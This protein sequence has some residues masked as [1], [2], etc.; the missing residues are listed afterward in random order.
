[1]HHFQHFTDGYKRALGS[2]SVVLHCVNHQ[3]LLSLLCIPP[4]IHMFYD[5]IFP[6]TVHNSYRFGTASQKRGAIPV[7]RLYTSTTCWDLVVQGVQGD[8]T[9]IDNW[10]S[11]KMGYFSCIFMK[12]NTAAKQNKALCWNIQVSLNNYI[13]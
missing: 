4:L 7:G 5:P 8:G 3:L 9:H 12:I 2:H 13:T 6:L 1:M 11:H 10:F